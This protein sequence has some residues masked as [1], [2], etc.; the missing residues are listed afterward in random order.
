MD[1]DVEACSEH[2]CDHVR[3]SVAGIGIILMEICR[4]VVSEID[5][6]HL[7]SSLRV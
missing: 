5:P 2:V 7:E 3:R 1:N 4:H 6:V